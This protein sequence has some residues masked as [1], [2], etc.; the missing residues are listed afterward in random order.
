MLGEKRPHQ[1]ALLLIVFTDISQSSPFSFGTYL[2]TME[3][4][5]LLRTDI[6]EAAI[7]NGGI[8]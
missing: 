2:R 7:A 3:E 5:A 6:C 8:S 4:S 1:S